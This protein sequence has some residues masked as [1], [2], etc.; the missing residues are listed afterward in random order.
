MLDRLNQFMQDKNAQIFD[1][2]KVGAEQRP[3]LP[4]FVRVFIA[5][6]CNNKEKRSGK[7]AV[8][9]V[10]V[11]TPLSNHRWEIGPKQTIGEP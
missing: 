10:W 1:H 3:K 5:F 6:C 4:V 8:M 7:Y 2:R 11:A 9:F